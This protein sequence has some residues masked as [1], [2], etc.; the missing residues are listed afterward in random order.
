MNGVPAG[1]IQYALLHHI[2]YF[3][4]KRRDAL[5]IHC[6]YTKRE[7]RLMGV[8]AKLL[9]ALIEEMKKPNRVFGT[10]LADCS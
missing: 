9:E 2:P 4:T 1:M 6:I 5:Y 8:A 3:T 7:F 10:N